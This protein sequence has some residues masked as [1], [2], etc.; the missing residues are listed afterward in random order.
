MISRCTG[1]DRQS[2]LA[3]RTSLRNPM[4]SQPS[5]SDGTNPPSR[6]LP[7]VLGVTRRGPSSAKLLSFGQRNDS[8]Q[9]SKEAIAAWSGIRHSHH[10]AWRIHL[11]RAPRYGQSHYLDGA[12]DD[13]ID[14]N[15]I[16]SQSLI[17]LSPDCYLP[18]KPAKSAHARTLHSQDTQLT[19]REAYPQT[20]W[21]NRSC[22]TNTQ[23]WGN[24]EAVDL[25]ARHRIGE[26]DGGTPVSPDGSFP[27][28]DQ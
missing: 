20:C 2:L 4:S 21:S 7:G 16:A 9:A 24:T 22:A 26:P 18:R 1:R 10:M 13:P 25:D 27:P 6:R 5:K 11:R 15:A 12:S 28:S 19:T 14:R 8:S 3:V 23:I 17:R